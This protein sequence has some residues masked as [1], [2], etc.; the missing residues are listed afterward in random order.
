MALESKHSFWMQCKVP[1]AIEF[2]WGAVCCVVLS[3]PKNKKPTL[4]CVNGMIG[5]YWLQIRT[6]LYPHGCIIF[7]CVSL[8][9]CTCVNE[10]NIITVHNNREWYSKMLLQISSKLSNKIQQKPTYFLSLF[11]CLLCSVMFSIAFF[12]MF[13][14]FSCIRI[15]LVRFFL[16]GLPL[17]DL[18]RMDW[19]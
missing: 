11:A 5:C 4:V 6:S 10:R 12:R 19:L 14:S 16:V 13:F 1:K 9:V 17:N 8:S 2:C 15:C 3:E 7:V 18:N